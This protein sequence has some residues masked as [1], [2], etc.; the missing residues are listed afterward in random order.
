MIS[1]VLFYT[2]L[3]SASRSLVFELVLVLDLVVDELVVVE[4]LDD[5]ELV[6]ELDD[7]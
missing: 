3:S 2:S 5:E 7:E 6:V 4:E 1:I